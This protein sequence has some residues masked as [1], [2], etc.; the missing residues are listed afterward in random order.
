MFRK[1]KIFDFLFQIEVPCLR[2]NCL[3]NDAVKIFKEF[4]L[5]E[6]IPI[7]DENNYPLG[8]IA[9]SRVF[10][11]LVDG[12]PPD[13]LVSQIMESDFIVVTENSSL[14]DIFYEERKR[15]VIAVDSSKRFVGL[16]STKDLLNAYR[17]AIKFLFQEF[18]ILIDSAY[19]GIVVIDSEGVI[20]IFNRSAEKITGIKAGYAI[21]RRASQIIPNTRLEQV[22]LTGKA[23]LGQKQEIGKTKIV[24]NR[25]PIVEDGKASGVVAVFQDLTELE[26]TIESL[27]EAKNAINILE[28]ILDYAYEGITV[29]DEN[30]K[31]IYF[32]NANST[33]L[34]IEPKDAIG[35][36]ISEVLPHSRL[37]IVLQTGV[38]EIRS[39]SIEGENRIVNRI[40]IKKDGEIVG[41]MGMVLFKEIADLKELY[42][43]LDLLESRVEYYRREL[44]DKWA[45]KYTVNDII[46][47][48]KEMLGLRS[49]MARVAKTDS[50]ILITG[51]TGT[52]K[53]LFAHAIHNISDRR[54]EHFVRV[55]CASISKELLESELFGYEPGAF[56]GARKQGMPGKFEL[57]NVG[58]IF[59]DEISDMPVSMQAEL[60]RVLQEKEVV[61][62]GGTKPIR[63]DFRVIAATNQDLDKLVKENRF[64]QDLFYRLDVIRINLPPLRKIK[65]D[66]APLSNYYAKK[67]GTVIGKPTIRIS[68][69]VLNIFE[70]YDWPGNTRELANVIEQSITSIR[71]DTIDL[72][73]LPPRLLSMSKGSISSLKAA[74]REGKAN[75]EKEIILKALTMVNG[76]RAKA[77]KSLGIHRSGLYQKLRKYNLI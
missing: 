6:S 67:F 36:N 69:D 25:T 56:T 27:G 51:E 30:E 48:S 31:I 54:N 47:K 41:A 12:L 37:P 65:N 3:I 53:E 32:N 58:T 23:E 11:S 14:K 7:V 19:N 34:G 74:L 70:A 49:Q 1:K 33:M 57:A 20:R 22:L 40:P 73:N 55:N 13:A 4:H 39:S 77:A 63:I 18:N 61:R 26:K 50:T 44:D 68:P 38:P 21:G 72:E 17:A 59:L 29:I 8:V 64:R 75:T 35:K 66:I 28:T 42:R 15:S 5:I 43:K 2:E 46:G 16:V 62:V 71:N 45:S 9:R 76:N 10:E 24:T 60:L 52:G